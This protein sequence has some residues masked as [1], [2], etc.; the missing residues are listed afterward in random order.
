MGRNITVDAR[1]GGGA[2][3]EI[4]FG[5]I[6]IEPTMLRNDGNKIVYPGETT[7][8]VANGLATLVNV[9]PSPI[10]S[11]PA[12]AYRV[13]CIDNR[14]GRGWSELVGVPSGTSTIAY[15]SLPR[16]TT[17]LPPAQQI[18]N[19]AQWAATDA[20]R[21]EAAAAEATAPTDAT[22]ANK[23]NTPGTLTNTA[24]SAAIGEQISA[25][26]NPSSWG[27]SVNKYAAGIYA[28]NLTPSNTSKWRAARD[29]AR[30]G[31]GSAH[32]S[33]HLDSI[34][35]GAGASF[36][37]YF[38]AWPGRLA[39]LLKGD[40]GD[41]GTGYV[42][43][44]N[45]FGAS[46][47]PERDARWNLNGVVGTTSFG[48]FA[49]GGRIIRQADVATSH[50]EFTAYG[51]EFWIYTLLSSGNSPRI[52]ID[53]GAVGTIGQSPNATG[54]TYPPEPGYFGAG[55]A[56]G[57]I[58]TKIPLTLGTHTI[59]LM[60]PASA[61]NLVLVGIDAQIT[62]PKVRVSNMALSSMAMWQ[63]VADPANRY[64]GIS[65]SFDL[66]N[67]DLAIIMPGMND[68]QG[69]NSV[70]TFK[71]DVGRAIDRQRSSAAYAANGDVLLATCPQ[72]DYGSIP[73]DHVLVPP[74]T[75]YYRALYELADEKNVPLLDLARMWKDYPTGVAN[76]HFADKLHPSDVGAEN[77]A[78]AIHAVLMI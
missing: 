29:A 12:W 5:D 30:S 53:G 7:V 20:D 15:A 42:V 64:S 60:A 46:G 1:R 34:A 68:F 49:A 59:R 63:L 33:A 39:R 70:A 3:H 4:L 35:H 69:H 67:A 24:L 18:Q 48:P 37:Y 74:L 54:V 21:A 27:T 65:H 52:Q 22:V 61:G 56:D 11:N 36:P 28:Y 76:S 71:T 44:W 41:G 50:I 9:D 38:N 40:L 23:I 2:P 14:T 47:I 55:T 66:P 17:L 75:S 16:Y 26:L 6:T 78:R 58:V 13:T 57:H 31:T 51:N 43:P 77:I 72:P 32:V 19:F 25:E 45:I 8:G 62:G 73:P 10:T